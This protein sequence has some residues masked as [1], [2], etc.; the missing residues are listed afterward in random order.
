M[1]NFHFASSP[2][3]SHRPPFVPLSFAIQIFTFIPH[4]L[5][6]QN[7]VLYPPTCQFAYLSRRRSD[8][9]DIAKELNFLSNFVGRVGR[10]EIRE[11]LGKDV[12]KGNTSL[13]THEMKNK[14][15]YNKKN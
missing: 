13:S 6:S 8:L 3:A 7:D 4:P 12:H 15:C 14:N 2:F 5:L 1:H 10:G 9:H 11:C